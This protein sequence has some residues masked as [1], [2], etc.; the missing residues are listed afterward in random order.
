MDDPTP[1]DVRELEALVAE[2]AAHGPDPGRT[3]GEGEPLRAARAMAEQELE[4]VARGLEGAQDR[5]RLAYLAR[6]LEQD[7]RRLAP[8]L[9]ARAERLRPAWVLAHP[10]CRLLHRGRMLL[11]Q[12]FGTA[13]DHSGPVDPASDLAALLVALES[14]DEP[15]LS[16]RVLDDYLRCSGD[17]ASARL[18]SLFRVCHALAGARLALARRP[19]PAQDG[20]QPALLAETM[21]ACRRFLDLAERHAEFRFPPLV[22]AVGV[23][24]SGKSRFTAGL[25]ERLGAVRLCSGVERRRLHGIEP[26]TIPPVDIFSSAATERTY[27]HLAVLAGTLL[28]AGLP[29]C[30]DATCLARWQRDLLRQQAEARGLPCLLVSFEADEAT[31]RRRIDKRARRQGVAPAT[32]LAVL[33]RQHAAFEAFDDDERLQLV[34]L[35][36]TADDAAETLAG[37][38]QEHVRLT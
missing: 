33:E 22:I 27:R 28:D 15:G 21:V 12:P 6:W 10:R 36:T 31:L 38:I 17:Y 30:V 37:L 23:S 2:L 19:P 20:E 7:I 26:G 1:Q 32:S 35:D 5:R 11:G 3:P 25:V 4:G 16:R 18:I 9:D 34:H 24:G 29:A 14:H 13:G 8:I